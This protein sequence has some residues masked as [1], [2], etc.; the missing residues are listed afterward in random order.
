MQKSSISNNK[1][2]IHEPAPKSPINWILRS[3]RMQTPDN[4]ETST[5]LSVLSCLKMPFRSRLQYERPKRTT[6]MQIVNDSMWTF[7]MPEK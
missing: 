3:R 7:H 1:G 2:L 6:F 5:S 4:K